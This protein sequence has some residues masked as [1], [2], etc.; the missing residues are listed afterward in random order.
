MLGE[1]DAVQVLE[2][3]RHGDER[4]GQHA[5]QHAD[6]KVVRQER[7][8]ER[9]AQGHR[10]ARFQR[11]WPRNQ[12]IQARNA[13]QR[14]ASHNQE[15][16]RYANRR[17]QEW[18]RDQRDHKRAADAHADC[19]HCPGAPL[20]SG[21]VGQECHYGPGYGAGTLHHAGGNYA[22][23]RAGERPEE[24]AERVQQKSGRYHRSPTEPVG[25]PPERDLQQRLGE[26][27]GAKREAGQ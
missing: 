11:R 15:N 23:D 6:A 22:A 3:E 13:Q 17:V 21:Q 24:R 27:V 25:Q 18:R 14:E 10:L 12:P 7:R 2:R 5:V 9:S 16:A 8:G 4:R 26:A 1:R 19:R 20:A